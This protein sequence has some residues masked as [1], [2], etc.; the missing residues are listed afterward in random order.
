MTKLPLSSHAIAL[1]LAATAL[2]VGAGFA[3]AGWMDHG[4]EMFLALAA[5][6]LSWCF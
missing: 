2:S 5:S 1:A 6:G 4:A 3:F